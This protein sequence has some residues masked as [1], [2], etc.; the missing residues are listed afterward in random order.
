MSELSRME[1][2]ALNR[3]LAITSSIGASPE[4]LAGG[5]GTYTKNTY[6]YFKQ[7]VNTAADSSTVIHG[8]EQ[9]RALI[10]A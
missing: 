7:T 4:D 1:L 6:N 5:G 8:Y 2:P 9:M 3:E 10:G